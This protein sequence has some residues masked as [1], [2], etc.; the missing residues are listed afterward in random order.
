MNQ[1]T[2]ARQKQIKSR[3]IAIKYGSPYTEFEKQLL[4]SPGTKAGKEFKALLDAITPLTPV[5]KEELAEVGPRP[6]VEE[7]YRQDKAIMAKFNEKHPTEWPPAPKPKP[8]P[9]KDS[10]MDI[11]AIVESAVLEKL[12]SFPGR[13]WTTSALA[14][15][16]ACRE[17]IGMGSSMLRQRHLKTLREDTEREVAK[18]YDPDT[19]KWRFISG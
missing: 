1:W 5:E 8:A 15:S 17:N 12:K 4:K 14:E 3:M 10:D 9:V 7:Q 18:H 13:E 19:R 11:L 2:E 6:S 16:V